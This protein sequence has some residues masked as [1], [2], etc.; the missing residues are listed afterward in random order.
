MSIRF[1]GQVMPSNDELIGD[2]CGG[3]PACVIFVDLDPDE[4]PSLHKHPYP[5]LFFDLEGEST[6]T[7]GSESRVVRAGEMVIAE[8]HQPHGF[9]N[10]GQRRLR[11]IDI[12]LS[13]RFDT[14]W[15]GVWIISGTHRGPPRH[16][17]LT[18]G[19]RW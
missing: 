13:P 17:G 6:F 19:R 10:S 5:E 14:E 16:S 3:L 15:L 8:P 9:V 12:H 1:L 18:P 4:G 11:Q 2:D 7:Y